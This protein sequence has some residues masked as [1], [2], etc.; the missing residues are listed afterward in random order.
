MEKYIKIKQYQYGSIDL[1]SLLND[2][3]RIEFNKY[4][5]YGPG[6]NNAVVSFLNDRHDRIGDFIGKNNEIMIDVGAHISIF[7]LMF[8]KSFKKIY[9]VEPLPLNFHFLKLFTRTFPHIFP[10]QMAIGTENGDQILYIDNINNTQTSLIRHKDSL[11][12]IIVKTITLENFCVENNIKQ[13][14]FLKLDIEGK[15]LDLIIDSSFD[16]ISKVIKKAHIEIHNIEQ[17]PNQDYISWEIVR[18]RVV[19][20]LKQLNFSVEI[21]NDELFVTHN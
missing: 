1:L 18:E 21:N 13:I 15:E 16:N 3:E 7:S 4:Y 12:C 6:Y 8:N 10:C 17:T 9:S 5:E 14:D 19:N 20:K 2:Q 11:E